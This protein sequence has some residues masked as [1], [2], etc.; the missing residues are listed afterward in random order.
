MNTADRGI[1]PIDAALRR[2]FDF[3][4]RMPDPNLVKKDIEG[5]NGR[6][7]LTAINEQIVENLDRD[8]QIG[9]TYLM[10]V[11]TLD[12]LAQAFQTQII[13][14]LQEYFYDDWERMHSVLG[15]NAFITNARVRTAR[16]ST[17][18]RTMTASGRRRRAIK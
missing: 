17:C 15:G 8:H 14:L 10:K 5:V 9:H 2:R 13:P 18:Y 11:E 16:C 3:V 1:S 6:R 12:E 4:E 7:L